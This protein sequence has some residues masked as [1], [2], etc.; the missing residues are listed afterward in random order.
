MITSGNNGLIEAV[1]TEN[2]NIGTSVARVQASDTD[3]QEDGQ[4]RFF[5]IL[6]IELLIL[7]DLVHYF[8]CNLQLHTV[9]VNGQLLKS[10]QFLCLISFNVLSIWTFQFLLNVHK[11]LNFQGAIV[12]ELL[13]LGNGIGYFTLL[14]NGIV[15]TSRS[16]NMS[17]RNVF[18]YMVII[19]V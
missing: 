11:L 14:S 18:N 16:F 4:V 8:L 2:V 3:I 1:I 13:P 6:E 9:C 19:F 10:S 12:Y 15:E 5:S 7:K 17:Q